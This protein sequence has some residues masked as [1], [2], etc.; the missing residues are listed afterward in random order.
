MT[1]PISQAS[2]EEAQALA[3]AIEQSHE[4]RIISLL[5][6]ESCQIQGE[7]IAG[8]ALADPS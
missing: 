1:N 8:L 3:E 6:G 5:R 2:P 7:V 4:G